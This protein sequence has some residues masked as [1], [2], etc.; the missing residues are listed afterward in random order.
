MAVLLKCAASCA[1]ELAGA[2]RQ[3]VACQIVSWF[4][5]TSH[6][7]DVGSIASRTTPSFSALLLHWHCHLAA[8][9]RPAW[10]NARAALQNSGRRSTAQSL[11]CPANSFVSPRSPHWQNALQHGL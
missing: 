8:G 7:L 5:Y 10:S 2:S 4:R 11:L 3:I 9:G 1:R 6:Q